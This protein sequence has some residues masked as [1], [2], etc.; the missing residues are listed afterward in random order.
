MRNLFP[1]TGKPVLFV[2][3]VDEG[4]DAVP[5]VVAD[6][7]AAEGAAAVAVSA[8]IEAELAELDDEE[9]AAMREELGV[10][11]VRPRPRRARRL[12]AARPDRVLHRGRGQA[13]PVV[14]PAR[15]A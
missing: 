12:R 8:R 1:L 9:A 6:H 13:G 15:A 5:G 14:A 3:N 4:D 2:A 10:A 11:G 7:A